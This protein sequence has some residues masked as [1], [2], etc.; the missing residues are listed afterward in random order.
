MFP[1]VCAEYVVLTGCRFDCDDWDHHICTAYPHHRFQDLSTPACG[2][3]WYF[4][5]LDWA[6][7]TH[8]ILYRINS[9]VCIFYHSYT[10]ESPYITH[11]PLFLGDGCQQR[12]AQ[13]YESQQSIQK[14]VRALMMVID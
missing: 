10:V 8:R 1:R 4:I 11:H 9:A 7:H 3:L 13:F 5:Y 6:S 2:F 12:I 14:Y